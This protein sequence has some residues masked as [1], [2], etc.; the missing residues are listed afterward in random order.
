MPKF[1]ED[2]KAEWQKLPTAGKVAIGGGIGLFIL[3]LA[4]T[5][6]Q[7]GTTSA[8]GLTA[9]GLPATSGTTQAPSGAFPSTQS[10]DSTVPFIPSGV[11]P[12]FDSQGGLVAFQQGAV[13]QPSSSG[14]TTPPPGPT[15]PP[16][17]NPL[18]Y[19]ARGQ[20][21]S[22]NTS[23]IGIR[24]QPGGPNT[25]T[26]SNIGYGQPVQISGPAVQGQNNNP[27]T[28]GVANTN[29]WYPVTG[30]GYVSAA[31]VV[32]SGGG[33]ES[34]PSYIR[35]LTH[36]QVSYGDNLNA[37]AMQLRIRGGL[38]VWM[39]HNGNPENIVHGMRLE[40]PR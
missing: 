16:V 1:L 11:N 2:A 40:I 22:T 30:G 39:Q 35:N 19:L 13:G 6:S 9:A 4:Y 7:G 32:P 18:T 27:V 17:T 33:G 23:G 10:G 3:Y 12:V 37:V 5:H 26:T 14:T 38:P 20:M 25:Q 15:S 34:L 28:S 24:N 31:D 36:Y 21:G 8:S 29:L